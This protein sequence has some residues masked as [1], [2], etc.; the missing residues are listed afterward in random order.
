MPLRGY[1]LRAGVGM[2]LVPLAGLWAAGWKDLGGVCLVHD[3]LMQKS[4]LAGGFG[5]G[6]GWGLLK[7][8]HFV[9]QIFPSSAFFQA[10]SEGVAAGG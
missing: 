2:G 8:F 9:R 7:L 10:D 6:L 4:R 3:F 5:G 1:G